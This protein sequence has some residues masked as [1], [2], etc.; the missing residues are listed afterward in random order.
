MATKPQQR[1]TGGGG[2][3]PPTVLRGFNLG[4][5][6][7]IP[8]QLGNPQQWYSAQNVYSGPFG[9]LARARFAKVVTSATTGYTAQT[10]PFTSLKNFL[11]NSPAASYLLGDVNGFLYSFDTSAA[12]TATKRLNPYVDPSGAGNTTSL[13]GPWSREVYG[14][15]CYEM[16]GVTSQ[17]G[18]AANAATIEGFGLAAPDSSAAVTINPATSQAMSSIT[19]SNNVVTA[20][21]AA[22]C[23]VTGNAGLFSVTGCSDTSFNGSFVL[24]SGSGTTTWT[25][26]QVGQ[27]S[28]P[29]TAGSVTS[30]LNKVVGRSYMWAWEN[31]NKAHVSAPSPATQYFA[32]SNQYNALVF[33]E[34]GTVAVSSTS[35]TVTG[36]GSFFTAAWIGRSLFVD[37]VGNCGRIVAVASATS[38]SLAANAPSTASGKAFQVF[39]PAATHIRVYATADGGATYLR[40]A[41]NAFNAAASSLVGAGLSFSDSANGEPPNFPFTNETAQLYNLIPPIGSF[42]AQY[43]GTIIVYGV[44]GTP[45]TFYYSNTALTT[46]GLQ[47]ESFAPLNQFTLPIQDAAI[48]GVAVF[49]SSLVIW[50]STK[51]MFR[52]TGLLTDNTVA[53]GGQ[54]GAT[55]TRLPYNLG[56]ATPF[57]VVMTPLGAMWLTPNAELWL[58][59]DTYAPRNVGRPVQ[60]VLN[61]IAKNSLSNTRATYYHT[62]ERNWAVWAISA[63][64]SSSNNQ[65]LVLDLDML[66]SNGSPSFFVFDMAINHPSFYPYVVNGVAL[67]TVY[68]AGGNVRLFASDIDLVQDVDWLGSGTGT[69]VAVN[70]NVTLQAWGN[71]TSFLVKWPAWVRF[72]TNRTPNQV[73]ADGWNFGINGVDD[74]IY[75]FAAPLALTLTP[76]TNDTFTLSGNAGNSIISAQAGETFRYGPGLFRIGRAANFMAGRRLQFVIN[77]PTAAGASYQVSE[78]QFVPSSMIAPINA[79]T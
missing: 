12:Y 50:S 41:R 33:Q 45:Q 31:A 1:P 9:Y 49:P 8:P 38:L 34:P 11:V 22:A 24:T 75:T 40:V 5:N 43:Q 23:S 7:Y 25:W 29:S 42:L 66:A 2:G 17:A 26:T 53:S 44:G 36:T 57:S 28:T 55:L 54:Q 76:G 73:L 68:E 16:N 39:D 77:F 52:L 47:Q 37:G 14:G 20:T 60:S 32:D 67:E 72:V 61:T 19:R 71:D 70:G 35:T 21:F 65:L 3:L 74:D 6:T 10:Q 56:C 78:I 46:Q 62:N 48:N 51:D 64:G 18:R 59:T 58:F 79:L 30:A 4:L 63:N 69:E 15:I 13:S 27:N